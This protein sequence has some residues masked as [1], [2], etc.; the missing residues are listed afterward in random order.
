MKKLKETKSRVSFFHS[1]KFKVMILAE[2][3][4]VIAVVGC[5][6]IAL[7]TSSKLIKGQARNSMLSLTRS[8]A[9][10]LEY[11]ISGAG[12]EMPVEM[13]EGILADTRLEGVDSSYSYLVARDGT[14]LYHPTPEKSGSWSRMMQ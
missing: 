13:L 1:L 9:K 10:M 6:V 14:M 8:S 12:G 5:I 2:I 4:L 7:P 3:F 11:E